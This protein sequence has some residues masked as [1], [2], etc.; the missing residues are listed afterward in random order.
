MPQRSPGSAASTSEE[1]SQVW[2]AKV[3]VARVEPGRGVV[4]IVSAYS[5]SASKAPQISEGSYSTT[6]HPQYML[7]VRAGSACPEEQFHNR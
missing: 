1:E 7:R 6:V 4:A 5:S 2:D 3:T